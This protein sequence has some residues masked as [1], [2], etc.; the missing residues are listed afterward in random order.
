MFWKYFKGIHTQQHA[1][2]RK[3][4][5]ELNGYIYNFSVDY[6]IANTSKIINIHIFNASN[7]TKCVCVSNQ[8]CKIQPTLINLHPHNTVKNYTTIHLR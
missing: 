5:T 2:K 4:K 7:H 1:K 3:K 8:K 6:N